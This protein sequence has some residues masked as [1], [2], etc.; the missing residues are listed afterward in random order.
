MEY[1][2]SVRFTQVVCFCFLFIAT[3]STWVP[4]LLQ[5]LTITSYSSW[6]PPCCVKLGRVSRSCHICSMFVICHNQTAVH[7]KSI[8]FNLHYCCSFS[9]LYVR[10]RMFASSFIRLNATRTFPSDIQ[11]VVKS[12]INCPYSRF[13]IWRQTITQN[14]FILNN[15]CEIYNAYLCRGLSSLTMDAFWRPWLFS[16]YR[17]DAGWKYVILYWTVIYFCVILH[18]FMCMIWFDDKTR[19]HH[20]CMTENSKYSP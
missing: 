18:I 10:C 17:C 6:S 9:Y 1:S 2:L 20:F 7:S 13:C 3:N 5:H 15:A 19:L 16:L 4:R 8:L 12:T 14:S 11:A